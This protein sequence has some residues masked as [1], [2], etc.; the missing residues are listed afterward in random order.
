MSGSDLR[1]ILLSFAYVLAVL[2]LADVLRRYFRVPV[3]ATRKAVHIAVGM[4]V[5]PTLFLFEHRGWALFPPLTFALLNALSLRF[6]FFAAI[7]VTERTPGTVLFPL[8][9]ALL[10]GL[11]WPMGRPDLAACGVMAM[12]WGDAMAAIVGQTWGQAGYRLWGRRKTWLGSLACFSWTLL[13]L[14]LTLRFLGR[15]EPPLALGQAALAGL[16][17][18]IAEA[19]SPPGTDNLTV[20]VVAAG[21]LFLLG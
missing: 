12:T 10:L 13:A 11:F 7:E 5:F 9:F 15:L 14:T 1:A 16:G 2:L 21:L 18:T 6:R 17:A 4:W 19:L 3:A 20:P 8:S